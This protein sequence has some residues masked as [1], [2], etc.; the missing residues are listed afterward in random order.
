MEEIARG[1]MGVVYKARHV[2]LNRLIALKTIRA[3]GI[4]SPAFMR[5]FRTETEAVASLDHP[6]IVPIYDVNAQEGQPYFT[7]KLIDGCGLDRLI[8]PDGFRPCG[9][10]DAGT[11]LSRRTQIVLAE[12]MCKVARA[13]HHAHERG[14]IHRDLKPSNILVNARNEPFLTDFGIAK[15]IDQL[16]SLTLSGS[17]IGT[18]SYMAPEQAAGDTKHLTPAA[19]VFSLGAILYQMLT[20][21]PPFRGNTPVETL[22]QITELE[23]KHPTTLN[24]QADRELATIALKCLEKKPSLRYPSAEALANDLQRWL[25]QEPILAR[26]SGPALRLRRW[27]QRKPA[28]AC[29][30]LVLTVM[31]A[32][33]PLLFNLAQK[34]TLESWRSAKRAEINALWGEQ[35]EFVSIDSVTRSKLWGT[36]SP[37]KI[38]GV[39]PE[40]YIIGVYAHE[41]PLETADQFVPLLVYLEDSISAALRKTVRLDLRIYKSNGSARQALVAGQVDVMRVASGPYVRARLQNAGVTPLVQQMPD[42]YNGVVFVHTNSAIYSM[43]DLKRKSKAVSFA[44]GDPYSTMSGFYGKAFLVQNGICAADLRTNFHHINHPAALSNVWN[45]R[46]DA[47]LAKQSLFNKF[48]NEIGAALRVIG[49]FQAASF[50]WA[51]RSNAPPAFIDAFKKSLVD[52]NS[53]SHRDILQKLPDGATNF[54]PTTDAEFD[55]VRAEATRAEQFDP[56]AKETP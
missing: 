26:R 30:A 47:G 40:Q 1:G 28:T 12:M 20:G 10:Q 50:P 21:R 55:P 25:K 31:A 18:P 19:D 16:E 5:R 9:Q 34:A 49:T 41:P 7:M 3:E 48:T 4:T 43:A 13:V 8:T 11:S 6:N 2:T 52:L 46:F 45:G 24:G 23:P 36:A 39:S 14:I 15:V 53:T 51:A 17:I 33:A 54:I 56:S 22:R 29:L 27:A 35:N 32:G 42:K 37:P 38:G 44:F